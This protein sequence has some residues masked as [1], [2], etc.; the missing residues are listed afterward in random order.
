[1]WRGMAC[2]ASTT[3][4]KPLFHA[5]TK[6]KWYSLSSALM[7]VMAT[8]EKSIGV[9]YKYVNQLNMINHGTTVEHKYEVNIMNRV[10]FVHE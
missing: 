2:M 10:Q 1:M 6:S 4:R 5:N 8:Y 9:Y 3:H 7:V